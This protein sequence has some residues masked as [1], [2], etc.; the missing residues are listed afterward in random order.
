MK[1]SFPVNDPDEK[2]AELFLRRRSSDW[3]EADERGLAAWL[4]AST[5]H[6]ACFDSVER[7][8]DDA[9]RAAGSR[10]VRDLRAEALAAGPQARRWPRMAALAATVVLVLAGGGLGAIVLRNSPVGAKGE[11]TGQVYRT[12]V[13]E[14]A[15]VNLADGSRLLLNT[16][17][18][19]KVDF[20]GRR[21]GLQLV[22]GEAWFDVA[23]DPSRPFVVQ[24]G[25]HTVTALGTSF[26]VRMEPR[27]ALKVAVVEGRVALDA[28]GGRHVAD[29][30]AGER[31]DVQGETAVLRPAGPVAGDWRQGRIEFASA[32]LAEAVAEM[33]RYRL[34][35]IVVTDPKVGLMRV[36]GVF[37]TGEGSGFLDALPIT[38]PVSVR[39]A[40][41]VVLI[42]PAADKKTSSSY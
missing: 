34:T 14:R 23:K 4:D 13:G 39:V 32:T 24:A 12:A 30:R 3:N 38:H 33:N 26:D 10:G 15:T 31:I 42:G 11:A 17:S 20:S 1:R 25:A 19:V 18:E 16:S 28:F 22:S 21:R 41:G 40:Q 8:W 27:G 6:R 37:Y 29:V 5:V 36:S 35:P 7:M 9:G 2:A